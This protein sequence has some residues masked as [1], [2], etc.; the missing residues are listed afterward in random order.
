M[1]TPERV[2]EVVQADAALTPGCKT[3][4]CELFK[5]AYRQLTEGE[6]STIDIRHTD[7][8]VTMHVN[9]RPDPFSI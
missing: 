1:T 9:R 5:V 7:D 3:A 6:G 2:A 8:D 4:L